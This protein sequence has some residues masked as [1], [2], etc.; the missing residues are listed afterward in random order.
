MAGTAAALGAATAAAALAFGAALLGGAATV[1]QRVAGAADAAA[2]AAADVASGAVPSAADA[3][4]VA[5]RVARAAGA[6]LDDCAVDEQVAV[7]QVSAAYAG[8]HAVARS[9][10]APPESAADD[11]S[12]R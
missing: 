6:R 1:S 9:R 5:A 3:C 12:P 7:V 4:T 11:G 2:L 10:A 8:T